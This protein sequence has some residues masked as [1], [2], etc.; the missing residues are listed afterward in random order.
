MSRE[1]LLGL[2]GRVVM[3]TGAGRGYGRSIALAYGRN[4]ATVVTVDPDVE[5][6]TAVASEVE[7]LGGT[8][9]PI[10]GD[11]SVG[12]DVAT[13]FNKIE[14]LYGVLD[15]I[16]HVTHTVSQ[17]PFVE[18][19]ESE[20]YEL[21]NSDVKSSLYTLQQGLKYLAGGGFVVVVMPPANNSEPHVASVR[22]AMRGLIEGSTQVFP[23]TVRVNGVIP[24]REAAGE[25][26]DAP[27]AR[28]VVALGSMVS[29][30]I[31][32]EVIGVELPEPP[33]PPELYDIL[34]ELP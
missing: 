33:Q 26:Y 25:E 8:A 19:L 21:L 5:L 2:A 17:T 23:K 9:I 22:G 30:G 3:I 27:L 13:T 18:L 15:G 20:W 16:V 4:K 14:E 29:E 28:A 34:S 24:S 6:A 32:G 12:L 7:E 10:R 1:D 11:M 31:H